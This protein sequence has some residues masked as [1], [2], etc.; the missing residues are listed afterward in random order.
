AQ[1]LFD[2][3]PERARAELADLERLSR[4]ALTDVRR[5][6]AGYREVT[7]PGE[8]ARARQALAAA[9]IEAEVPNSTDEVPS[10]LRGL[11]AWTIREG[12]TNVIRHSGARHC[13]IRLAP[14]QVEIADDGRGPGDSTPGNGLTGLR[15]RAAARGGVVVTEQLDPGYALRVVVA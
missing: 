4:D 13:A 8:L 7:L 12:V 10:G 2:A 15:E 14:G 1:R 3:D 5:A 6:V 9:E 11:F